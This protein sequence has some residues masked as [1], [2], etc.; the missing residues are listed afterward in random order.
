MMTSKHELWIIT[1]GQRKQRCEGLR[2]FSRTSHCSGPKAK[3][4]ENMNQFEATGADLNPIENLFGESL[5]YPP[6]IAVV[7]VCLPCLQ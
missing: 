5:F 4:K 7:D 1:L 6:I 3:K 2:S